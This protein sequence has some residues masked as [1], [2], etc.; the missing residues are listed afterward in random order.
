M[1]TVAPV[2]KTKTNKEQKHDRKYG[3][4]TMKTSHKKW[5]YCYSAYE[6]DEIDIK[7]STLRNLLPSVKSL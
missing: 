1:H 3:F 6:R 4:A 7:K 5:E 2:Q